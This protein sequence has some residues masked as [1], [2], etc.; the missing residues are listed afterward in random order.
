MIFWFFLWIMWFMLLFRI[1]ADL[2]SDHDLS[3]WAKVGWTI[4]VCLL[5]FIGVFIYLVARGKG[6]AER[7]AAHAQRNKQE[8][9]DYIRQT[10]GAGG[11]AASPAEE[12]AKLADLKSTGAISESEYEQAKKKLLAV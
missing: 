11:G 4:L 5:P 1:I 8:F 6:M 10:A 3:G 9:D 2:F 12:L 7:S